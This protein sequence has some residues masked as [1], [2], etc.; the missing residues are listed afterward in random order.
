M[1][2]FTLTVN[3]E[4]RRFDGDAET[5]L[6]W[7]LRD[8]FDLV[9]TKFG[10]GG[11]FCG[12]CTVHVDGQARRSCLTPVKDVVSRQIT[13]IEGLSADGRHRLQQAWIA[14]DVPQ[15]GYC[16]AGQIMT[17]AALLSR[18]PNPTGEEITAGMSGNICRCGT[19]VRIGKAVRA[20][21]AVPQVPQVPRVP[22]VPVRG[23]AGAAGA[24]GVCGGE[25]HLDRARKQVNPSRRAFLK[26]SATAA[27]G[28]L[29]AAYAPT[30][31]VSAQS[32]AAFQPNA[33]V[34]IDA[35]DTVT[36]WSRNPEMGEG[37]KTALSMIVADELDAD[38]RR[39]KIEDAPLDRRFGPQGVGGS[40]AIVSG[41]DDHRRAGAMARHLIVSVAASV[42]GVPADQIT[43]ATSVVSHSTSNRS[44]RYGELAAR[45][46][47][48]PAPS[49]PLL[50]HP[51]KFRLIGTRTS[52]VDN[53]AI[54]TGRRLFGLDVKVTGMRYAAIAKAPVF[55]QRAIS[56][57]RTKALQVPGVRQVVEIQ[58]RDNPTQL[59]PGVAVIADSTWAAFKG[60]EALTVR[61]S[62]GP[63]AA[64]SSSTLASQMR[65][66]LDKPAFT[67]HESGNVEQALAAA[68]QTV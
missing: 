40:D 64:E 54:V 1:A 15:C 60:R 24:I 44:S 58:G 39:V 47:A 6:L 12:A 3:S 5:P 31:S 34:R 35:D 27:G 26:I 23:A 25:V 11:G 63:F 56:V 67:L 45:A 20:G 7:V 14:T 22:Q 43:T 59:M 55:G 28:L 4:R 62:D 29:V 37:V 30:G 51:S 50:K 65:E 52:G 41:W 18:T 61:W 10:C 53:P 8:V 66:L 38:W 17:A 13:T 46:A 33:F 42:W 21:A 32:P 68:A 36:I 9:G 57:D 16:Q 19:Y 48:M 49:E 2:T